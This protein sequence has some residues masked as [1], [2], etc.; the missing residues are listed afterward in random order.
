[1]LLGRSQSHSEILSTAAGLERRAPVAAR[2]TAGA[3]LAAGTVL[4]MA[5]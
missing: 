4:L 5:A 2:A 1:V 3:L